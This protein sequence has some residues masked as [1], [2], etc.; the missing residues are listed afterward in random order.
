NKNNDNKQNNL[1]AN[2][3]DNEAINQ[4]SVSET[5]NTNSGEGLNTGETVNTEEVQTINTENGVE[6]KKDLSKIIIKEERTTG[7]LNIDWQEPKEAREELLSNE[8]QVTQSP[9][10]GFID[11]G[12]L[13]VYN[14]GKIN[15]GLYK[16]NNFYLIELACGGP[17]A[18]GSIHAI[19]N[20]N[21][22]I[23]LNI[24]NTEEYIDS[25]KEFFGS[26]YELFWNKKIT[27]NNLG[28][29]SNLTVNV[30]NSSVE[31]IK[32][33]DQFPKN[34][35][36]LDFADYYKLLSLKEGALYKNRT[37]RC[38]FMI[39]KD[40]M[41]NN[42]VPKLS[43]V[44]LSKVNYSGYG[45]SPQILRI[46]WL[47]GRENKE[48]YNTRNMS[49]C[50]GSGCLNYVSYI[51]DSEKQ[52]Q[53]VG[54]SFDGQVI[55][56]LKDKNLKDLN[57]SSLLED[58]YDLYYPGEGKE[59]IAFEDFVKDRPIVYWQ[60][61]FGDFVAFIKNK[62]TPAVECGKPVIYLYPEKETRVNVEVKPSGGFSITEP[63]YNN[64][65]KVLAKPNGEIYNYGDKKNYPYLFW[66]GKGLNYQMPS[67]GFVVKREEVKNFLIEKLIQLG[68]IE[69]EY[70]EFIDFWLPRMQ[71]KPY[72][73]ITFVPQEQFNYLAPLKI[74]P[75]PDTV[76]R[77]F[78]D[79]KGLNKE[80]KAPEQ[81][82]ITP[83]RKGFTV[84][85]WGG[86]LRK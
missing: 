57:D 29:F 79:Y 43:F 36:S 13:G 8:D 44:D 83:K 5:V 86:A 28:N 39:A 34:I 51:T 59:K 81:K 50:G 26:K 47:D 18:N 84:V 69:K 3:S 71:E 53:K 15:N 16:D 21:K 70:N 63:A 31:L 42:Y 7:S 24:Y 9:L 58:M 40:G 82:I 14:L 49:S 78:M 64:G 75:K 4:N 65:W 38:F 73:F 30:N 32:T 10:L 17:C 80:I 27:I 60:D 22:L 68:L 48:E 35:S 46:K 19:K 54:E 77:V 2:I 55:Y 56:E 25:L 66:E 61:V 23:F 67:E 41:I 85:E 45:Q 12:L 76:I 72:Y 62:Y 6:E 11:R 1:S 74:N 33:N 52:L 37:N 20:D